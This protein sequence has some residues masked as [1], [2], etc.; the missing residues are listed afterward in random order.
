MHHNTIKCP[1]KRP[2]I[3]SII[4]LDSTIVT[5]APQQIPVYK[6]IYPPIDS[7]NLYRQPIP[8]S[9]HF[10]YQTPPGPRSFTQAPPTNYC[11]NPNPSN[12]YFNSFQYY[13]NRPAPPTQSDIDQPNYRNLYY[14]K[15]Y[16]YGPAQTNLDRPR[17]AYAYP[18]SESSFP[19]ERAYS[20]P[21]PYRGSDYRSS[22]FPQYASHPYMYDNAYPSS[23]YPGYEHCSRFQMPS[24]IN[25][26]MQRFAR[27]KNSNQRINNNSDVD[28]RLH[29]EE[30]RSFS[31]ASSDT[32][33]FQKKQHKLNIDAPEWRPPAHLT[34]MET[35]NKNSDLCPNI[36]KSPDKQQPETAKT[37]NLDETVEIETKNIDDIKID[38]EI[39]TCDEIDES[40]LL[41]TG[42]VLNDD[43]ELKSTAL[44]LNLTDKTMKRDRIIEKNKMSRFCNDML[45]YR[46]ELK[47]ETLGHLN[48]F[49]DLKH[50]IGEDF[51]KDEIFRHLFKQCTSLNSGTSEKINEICSILS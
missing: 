1:Q 15:A 25:Q 32:P 40:L 48:L 39:E 49:L 8:R 31:E 12:T 47:R 23:L 3:L 37:V 5:N 41:P 22:F 28:Y 4:Y 44:T 19:R 26:A 2:I 51:S 27:S 13:F 38:N 11:Q 43:I 50:S 45:K 34:S 10:S 35:V 30:V 7:N 33:T 18:P 6:N 36:F 21:Y 24:D 46:D 17:N 16:Y 9:Y 29:S 14:D 20:H 42:H